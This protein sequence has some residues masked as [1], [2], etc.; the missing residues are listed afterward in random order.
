MDN[1]INNL[2]MLS[3]C[4]V[5]K[6]KLKRDDLTL[7]FRGETRTV[8]HASCSK[9]HISSLI[10]LSNS[11]K[12]ILGMGMITDLDKS[13]VKERLKAKIITADEVIKT[14]ISLES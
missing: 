2:E 3:R 7:V 1:R 8:F 9:C 13:E 10:F 5:C 6:S 4:P 11:K 14:Y 12:G